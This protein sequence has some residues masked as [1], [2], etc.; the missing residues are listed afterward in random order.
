MGKKVTHTVIVW[1]QDSGQ[2][3]IHENAQ[4]YQKGLMYHVF[5]VDKGRVFQY[6]IDHIWRVEVDYPRELQAHPNE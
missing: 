4:F 5:E 6:P 3:I 1:L 2:P